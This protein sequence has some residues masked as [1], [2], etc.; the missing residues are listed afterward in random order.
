MKATKNIFHSGTVLDG[1]SLVAHGKDLGDQVKMGVSA[2]CKFHG[3]SSELEYKLKMAQAGRT[4]TA[5]TIGLTD[6][7]E[8]KKGLEKIWQVTSDRGFYVDRFI[9]AL[10]R[11]M[12][13][14]PEYRAGALKETGPMLNSNSEWNEVA[15]S[16]QI[17]PHMGDMM[18]GSPSSVDNTSRALAAGVNYIGNLS[19]FA[20]KYPGWPGDD[21]AQ[22]SE[23]IKALGMMASKASQGAVVHSYLDDGFP[24]Q[25]G[26][27]SSYIGWAKFER[28]VVEELIGAKLAHAYGGLTHDPITKTVV[29]MAIESLRPSDVCSSFYFG[30]TTRYTQNIEQN[31][32][33][34]GVDVLYMMLAD[35]HLRAGSSIMPVPVTEAIRVPT[36]DEIIDVQT[37]AHHTKAKLDSIYEVTNWQSLEIRSQELV[38]NGNK[39]FDNLMNG[40]SELGADIKDPLQLLLAVR[41]LGPSQLEQSFGVGTPTEDPLFDGYEPLVPTDVLKDFLSERAKIREVV[42]PANWILNKSHKPVVASSDVHEIGMRLVIDAVESLDIKPVIGTVGIDPDELAELALQE[43]A[44]AVLI[45]T[46]NGMAL[47]YAQNLLAELAKRDISPQVIIGGRLNQEIEGQDMPVDVT[48]QLKALGIDVCLDLKELANLIRN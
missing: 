7:P 21:V 4:M 40:L 30:N 44:T 13:L 37:I 27:Y 28:Y 11:R 26:D 34:L 31:Y 24:A 41:R 9:I 20:W 2:F 8:T 19:Q 29:T 22:M 12:G 1:P 10:D 23:V 36:P 45:S 35:R 47:S 33:V 39:F 3:V 43:N 16:V 46:H 6:W 15:H 42:R 32:G 14:P 5:L 48:E 17:Q 18:I 38:K 25:F